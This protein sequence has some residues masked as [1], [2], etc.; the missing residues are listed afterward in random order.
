MKKT[1]LIILLAAALLF[2]CS[3][4]SGFMKSVYAVLGIDDHD[5][6]GEPAINSPDLQSE[7]IRALAETAKVLAYGKDVVPFD[8]FSDA[9][10]EY[11]DIVLEYLSSVLFSKYSSDKELLER[12]S[13][14]YPELNLSLL[15]PRSDYENTVYRCFGGNKKA[16]VKSSAMYSYLSKTDAFMLIGQ[17]PVSDASVRVMT[18]EETENTYRLSVSFSKD[19]QNT[20]VYDIIFRKRAEGEPYIWR[21]TKTSKVFSLGD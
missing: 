3:C 4:E 2:L 20:G 14:D 6:A 16:V 17:M 11:V 7:E 15:I 19:G 10:D 5:Y 8:S 21:V 18:A 1:V 9:A 12:F 13:E